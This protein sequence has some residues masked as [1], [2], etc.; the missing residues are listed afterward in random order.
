MG[1]SPFSESDMEH[2]VNEL[3]DSSHHFEMIATPSATTNPLMH[4]G[5]G[6]NKGS[7]HCQYKIITIHPQKG[8][9]HPC[10]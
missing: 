4:E 9:V 10:G 6:K 2:Y 8:P 7:F 5:Q 1:K 3:I